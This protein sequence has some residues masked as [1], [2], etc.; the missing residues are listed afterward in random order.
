MPDYRVASASAVRYKT[1]LSGARHA[2][3]LVSL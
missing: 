2:L 1:A 3:L